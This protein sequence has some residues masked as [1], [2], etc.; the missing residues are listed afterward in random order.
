M[1]RLFLVLK[2]LWI[3]H[4]TSLMVL[5]LMTSMW[6]KRHLN[7]SDVIT[8]R[9]CWWLYM[10]RLDIELIIIVILMVLSTN[11]AT[12]ITI[13]V[14]MLYCLFINIRGST[15]WQPRREIILIWI[16]T[17]WVLGI[18]LG[19]NLIGFWRVSISYIWNGSG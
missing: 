5:L 10:I 13:P 1:L 12:F 16:S 8:V 6:V 19:F 4:V 9:H 11:L 14:L 7:L 3:V 17:L 2:V 15:S 18:L